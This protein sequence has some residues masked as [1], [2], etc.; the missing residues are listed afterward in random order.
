MAAGA[1]PLAGV[2]DRGSS[3]SSSHPPPPPPPK[4]LL[5]KPPLPPPSSSGAD[6]D[7]GGG[8]GAGRSR[9]ATQP[10]SLSLVSDA[11][12]V[13]TD[14]ILPYLT[15]NNDFMVIGVIGPTGVGKST[16][17][18]ELYGYDGSSPGM[19]PPFATQTEEI[20]AMAKHCTAGID[21]RISNER[22]ILLDT[23]PVFSPSVLIDMMKPD[24][25]SA[26]PIL[27][28]DPL[29][30]DLAHELMGIQLGVFLASVCNILLVVSEGIN[31]LSM[32]DLILTVDLLKHNI[33][34]PSLL[35]SS[36]TQDKENK[37]DNQSG[38]EDYIADLCFVHARLREQD[39]SPSKLMVLKRV[40]E[41]HFKS[42]SFSIGSSGA[43]PQVSDSSVPSSMK[44]EDLSSNQ[45]DIYL[46]PLRTPDNSTN[47]EYRT[48]PS[49]LGMLRDQILSRPSRSFSK[50]LTERDWLRSSAKIWDMKPEAMLKDSET[51]NKFSRNHQGTDRDE[52][53]SSSMAASDL[54]HRPGLAIVIMGVSGCGKST[55]AA[56]LAETLGCSFIE[57]DDY[58]SQANKAKMS[59]GIPLTDG[60]RIPW[61]EALRDAVRERLDHGE[62]VA[63]SCSALQQKYREILREGD[64]SFRS[65]SGSYS[66]CRVKFVCLEAS[67][68]V[69]ADRIR[70]RSMEGEH[71]MPASLLQSQLDLLQIDE[72]EGITVVDATVRPNAIVHDTIARFREQLASTVC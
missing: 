22:V 41:K 34:D 27:S 23:Q 17:M 56:L 43:T 3:S 44:I 48:C 71:F 58:H 36:T 16:I 19:L 42:S 11:W 2:G 8:G 67:A 57:A 62:D 39:F 51:R 50:N 15:E 25:S 32:W 49:M 46:L 64:C 63:V 37:N 24:G 54:T 70:R 69:I 47:F 28:G 1:P 12:E 60:D 59:K 6:D 29:S 30:A 38:I 31:D 53:P 9:Q 21:I 66:S 72:A 55:V 26:I 61:L 35:T 4:I 52:P 20:K 33:P 68:E 40:L 65:G 7:G 45:Q 5:A 14:K 18:N 13:H 10:G